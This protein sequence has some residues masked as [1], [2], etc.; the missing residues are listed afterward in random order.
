MN[1]AR[2]FDLQLALHEYPDMERFL[3][4]FQI[5]LHSIQLC[6]L[7]LRRHSLKDHIVVF[8]KKKIQCM[9]LPLLNGNIYHDD[10]AATN[11]GYSNQTKVLGSCLRCRKFK[12]KCSRE[13]PECAN[14]ASCDE[15]CVY[16]TQNSKKRQGLKS[17]I[18][19]HN[20][21][22]IRGPLNEKRRCSDVYRLLN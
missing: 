2:D 13:L 15:I 3:G 22:S 10:V 8:K 21:T 11:G 19:K 16:P 7:P 5:R 14:C 1:A 20:G 17:R 9:L 12:K 6:H 18:D 4:A